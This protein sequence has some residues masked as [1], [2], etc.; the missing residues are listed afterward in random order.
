MK[1]IMYL[2][3]DTGD[4]PE[5]SLL[6]HHVVARLGHNGLDLEVLNS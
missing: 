3:A 6:S 4:V 5:S 1:K 2:E